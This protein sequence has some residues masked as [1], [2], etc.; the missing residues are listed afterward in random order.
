MS[1]PRI[2]LIAG[3]TGVGKTAAS[4][5]LA[6]KLDTDIISCDSMQIYKGMDI[7]T[8]KVTLEE[9][10]GVC[11]HMTDIADPNDNFSVADYV[12]MATPIV[13]EIASKGKPALLVG[14]TGLYA[15]SLIKGI[16]FEKEAVADLSYRKEMFEAAETKGAE[17][18]HSL[19]CK[20]D[21]ES[22]ESIHPNN[23]KRVIRALEYYHATGEKISVHN[24]QTQNNESPF[25][26]LRLYFTRDREKLYQRIDERVDVMVEMGLKDEVEKL[27]S[28]G[29]NR[30]STAMQALGYKEMADAIDGLISYD[31]AI[32][33]IK[34]DSRRYAK[35]Q[36]TWFRRDK[37]GIWINL[38]DA[39]TPEEVSG[40]CFDIIKERNML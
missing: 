19:L 31:E 33:I 28:L 3:P 12:E 29:I 32:E 18:V 35:R 38:D 14:G 22:A 20:V 16:P 24:L 7:G 36:L 23:V 6:K 13:Y 34:R 39:S 15:D 2:I 4:V 25:E 9:A 5:F 27:L 26:S 11:H 8:A 40:M 10:M 30:N 17:Y 37:E 21:P 1:K